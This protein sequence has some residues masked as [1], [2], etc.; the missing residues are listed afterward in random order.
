MISPRRMRAALPLVNTNSMRLMAHRLEL[1]AVDL[2][3]ATFVCVTAIE[4]LTHTAVL[5]HPEVLSDAA[6]GTLIDEATR[7]I[8]RY[9]R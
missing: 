4:G 1:R 6:V 7:L 2:A 9:L 5:H 3:L 8:V